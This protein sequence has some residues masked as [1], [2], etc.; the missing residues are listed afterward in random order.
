MLE[1]R[2]AE[3]A[4]WQQRGLSGLLACAV[5]CTGILHLREANTIGGLCVYYEFSDR[6]KLRVSRVFPVS[7]LV[8]DP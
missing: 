5:H 1:Q 8:I 4:S 3:L 2:E 7:E 6:W